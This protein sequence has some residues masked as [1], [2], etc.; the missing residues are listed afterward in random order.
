MENLLKIEQLEKFYASN[1][2]GIFCYLTN[3]KELAELIDSGASFSE[4]ENYIYQGDIYIGLV[5]KMTM[6]YGK[7]TYTSGIVEDIDED[8][9]NTYYYAFRYAFPLDLTMV[10]LLK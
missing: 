5:D 8:N 10:S 7:L 6:N 2:V 4:L 1:N 9:R 3:K